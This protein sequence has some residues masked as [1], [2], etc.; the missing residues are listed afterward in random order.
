MLN[1]DT[2]MI[3]FCRDL[4][5]FWGRWNLEDPTP[6]RERNA[7]FWQKR[8]RDLECSFSRRADRT[9]MEPI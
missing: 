9:Y 3:E 6:T 5:R 7:K 1:A 2:M 8:V 4:A